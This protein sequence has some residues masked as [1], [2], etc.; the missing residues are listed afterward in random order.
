MWK[1]RNG[2]R[3]RNQFHELH[4]RFIL[5]SDRFILHF[6]CQNFFLKIFEFANFVSRFDCVINALDNVDA[7]RHVNR[8]CLAAG[9][10]LIESGS[11]GY[12]GQTIVYKAKDVECYECIPKNTATVYAFCTIR[13]T[14]EKPI[15]AIIW[16]RQLFN[17]LFGPADDDNQLSDMKEEM[18]KIA[19]SGDAYG[20]F[21]FFFQIILVFYFYLTSKSTRETQ[22]NGCFITEVQCLFRGAICLIV[23][24]FTT[25]FGAD[26]DSPIYAARHEIFRALLTPNNFLF[27]ISLHRWVLSQRVKWLETND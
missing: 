1:S 20:F 13:S 4:N 26:F 3:T 12:V 10:A 18:E 7:R 25:L 11:T 17:L 21:F 16:A 19:S 9:K 8:V 5:H 23:S 2:I 24:D 27:P 14:P 6:C 15:H 22:Q